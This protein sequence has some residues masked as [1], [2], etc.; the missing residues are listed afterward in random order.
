MILN[1]I[2]LTSLLAFCAG[3]STVFKNLRVKEEYGRDRRK[4]LSLANFEDQNEKGSK[5]HIAGASKG[6]YIFQVVEAGI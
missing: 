5:C 2:V 1:F 6:V 4:S 3:N